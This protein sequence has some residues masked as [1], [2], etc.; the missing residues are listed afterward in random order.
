MRGSETVVVPSIPPRP[1]RLHQPVDK[2]E[3]PPFGRAIAT[4]F[5]YLILITWG[6][7]CDFLRY[8]GLKRDGAVLAEDVSDTIM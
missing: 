6:Y 3:P 1:K 4:Y 8:I 2:Y 7:I 5:G